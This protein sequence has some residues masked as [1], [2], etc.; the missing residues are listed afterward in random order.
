MTTNADIM[1]DIVV[2]DDDFVKQQDHNGSY[3]RRHQLP[4]K[5]LGGQNPLA[6]YCAGVDGLDLS[7]L[8]AYDQGCNEGVPER[9]EELLR[10][11][12][13]EG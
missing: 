4:S 5:V 11:Q 10:G 3:G 9:N 7:N 2:A 13:N 1:K 6:M 12:R 8:S